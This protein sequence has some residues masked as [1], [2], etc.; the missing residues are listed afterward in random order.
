MQTK[1][2]TQLKTIVDGPVVRT[3]SHPKIVENLIEFGEYHHLD[4]CVNKND[5][6]TYISIHPERI[7]LY[8]DPV[9]CIICESKFD[10]DDEIDELD[11]M[12]FDTLN[13]AIEF[14]LQQVH[15]EYADVEELCDK[16]YT[17]S[18]DDFEKTITI[19]F[20]DGKCC[21]YD[22]LSPLDE[23]DEFY[24]ENCDCD[25][26]DELM[27]EALIMFDAILEI[28]KEHK[29]NIERVYGDHV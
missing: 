7:Y 23:E 21:K 17:Y 25:V 13:D 19:E 9:Y 26:D 5:D 16:I 1:L 22:I 14:V 27:H 2:Y 11:D 18:K 12:F 3:D 24:D 20:A 4:I 29:K 8:P 10:N 15:D 28:Q 6:K